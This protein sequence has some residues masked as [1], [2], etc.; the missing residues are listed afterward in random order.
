MEHFTSRNSKFCKAYFI[1]HF[2]IYYRHQI[3]SNKR[4]ES[5]N[6]K[7]YQSKFRSQLRLEITIKSVTSILFYVEHLTSSLR[8]NSK[9]YVILF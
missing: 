1:T 6:S 3:F 4:H 2:C 7:A 5:N 9:F 8:Y